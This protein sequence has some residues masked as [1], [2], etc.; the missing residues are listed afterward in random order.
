MT[1][2]FS[3]GVV[4]QRYVNVASPLFAC[5]EPDR[6]ALARGRDGDVL[7]HRDAATLEA[8]EAT[9]GSRFRPPDPQGPARLDQPSRLDMDPAPVS[10]GRGDVQD[11]AHRDVA[12]R[13]QVD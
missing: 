9:R 10:R 11:T 2:G 8:D 12:G 6:A 7:R 5:S 1:G 4:V 13:A 3:H